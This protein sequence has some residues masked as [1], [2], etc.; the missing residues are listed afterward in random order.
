V[1][2]RLA[3]IK[4]GR[5]G[6]RASDERNFDVPSFRIGRG[7]ENDLCLN[8]LS[9]SLNHLQLEM[10]GRDL[11]VV[12][13]G[14]GNV[15]VNGREVEEKEIGT[16]DE[17][18]IGRFELRVVEPPAGVDVSL[19]LEERER[20]VESRAAL[21]KRTRIG[22]ER[23]LFTRRKLFWALCLAAGGLGYAVSRDSAR[24]EEAWNSGPI[25]RKHAFIANDCKRCHETAFEPVSNGACL[26][27]HAAV[28]HHTEAVIRPTRLSE[29]RCASC[30]VEHNGLRG[31]A[32]LGSG[33][34]SECHTDL[35]ALVPDTELGDASDFHS[36]H[37]QFRLRL[38]SEAPGGARRP[39]YREW[40]SDLRE[41][42]GV[43][44]SHLRHVGKSVTQPEGKG[45][46]HLDCGR[47][48]SLDAGGMYMRPISFKALCQDCHSLAFDD[49]FGD[50][51]A[52]HGDPVKMRKEL[53]EA[54]SN[55]L[56]E[57]SSQQNDLPRARR[58]SI[59]VR[60]GQQLT[61][62]ERQIVYR[63][64]VD[65]AEHAEERL[66]GR[67]GE[68]A[69][70]HE[71]SLSSARDGG[72][73]LQPVSIPS[74]WMPKSAFRHET[75]APFP[76][77]DCHPA[78]AVYD[79]DP[80]AA[81][82]RPAWSFPESRPYALFTSGELAKLEGLT[83]S[84]NAQDILVPGIDRCRDCHGGATAAPPL[85][86]SECVLCHP[87]HRAESGPMGAPVR[88]TTVER[89]E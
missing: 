30:H 4:T 72:R 67:D 14:A 57:G 88:E 87:F 32:A 69:R 68:C 81:T 76:C 10:R 34:C 23:G 56:L 51:Q 38:A 8:D 31:L 58:P 77:R 11:F 9:L 40:R 62:K 78:A 47:C 84:K 25:S 73:G 20:L 45:S 52:Y 27:C 53:I 26:T 48:H 50:R 21:D 22:V 5:S 19:E 33:L 49:V 66:M 70:C 17:I 3:S 2:V 16:G 18:R 44:F 7:T 71:P 60:P 61:Q 41:S 24:Y 1:R 75:H 83:A 64:A 42:P 12:Q 15:L 54:Y 55:L 59:F 29:A 43:R 82:P 35:A 85:V 13:R 63:W 80:D 74:V 89:L 36:R 39:E 46:D 28:G 37:P 79:P 65:Q 86:A 6:S